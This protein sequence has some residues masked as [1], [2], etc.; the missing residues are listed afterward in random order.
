MPRAP[1]FGASA[2]KSRS[3]AAA[4]TSTATSGC[5]SLAIARELSQEPSKKAVSESSTV[6]AF[7]RRRKSACSTFQPCAIGCPPEHGPEEENVMFK[8]AENNAIHSVRSG[9]YV[10]LWTLRRRRGGA[11]FV[12]RFR[13]DPHALDFHR[14][15]GIGK[16]TYAIRGSF[17]SSSRY[18]P[19]TAERGPLCVQFPGTRNGYTAS[20]WQNPPPIEYARA[21]VV[22]WVRVVASGG[23]FIYTSANSVTE[24]G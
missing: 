3:T 7:A 9:G 17:A 18:L 20:S 8:T 19:E 16:R 12:H 6:A 23:A 22:Q 2:T 4:Q 13:C 1:Q 10:S 14:T 15:S 21:D 11:F 5:A 24:I